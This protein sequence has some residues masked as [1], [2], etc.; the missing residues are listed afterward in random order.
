[1]IFGITS[2]V[3]LVVAV[4]LLTVRFLK[5]RKIGFGEETTGFVRISDLD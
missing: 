1:M 4:S 3:V 2:G 5:R